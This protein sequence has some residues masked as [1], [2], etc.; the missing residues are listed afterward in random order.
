M[1][2]L[3][4]K[5]LF[6]IIAP[7]RS[8]TSLMQE[9][10]NTFSNFCNN[11]ESRIAGGDSPSCW[12]FVNKYNDFSYL[13]N[14]I[15]K[16]WTSEFFIEK[17]PPS[18]NCI[19]QISKK[20]HDANFI[21]LKRNPLKIILSQLNLHNGISE[22]GTRCHDLGDLMINKKSI[23]ANREIIMAKRLLK[24]INFQVRF[25]H[26]LPN[27]IELKYEDI[28]NSLDSQLELLEKTFGIKANYKKAHKQLK[29][30]SYSSTFRYGLK[31]LTDKVATDIIKFTSKLWDYS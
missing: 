17:S 14:F 1:Q 28:V 27:R 10:M 22:I 9:I 31:E 20:Y 3:D 5:K 16:N 4:Q 24:M 23:I 8:G 19:P 11:S 2:E 15:R 7:D 12:E 21:L 25:K 13:E 26:L 18:I 6:F 30:P 29:T